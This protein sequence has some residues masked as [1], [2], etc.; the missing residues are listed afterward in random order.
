MRLL[1]YTLLVIV[2]GVSAQL[3]IAGQSPAVPPPQPVSVSLEPLIL[4]TYLVA[5]PGRVEPA[6]E[7]VAVGASV[8]GLVRAVAVKEGDRV[9]RGQIIAEIENDDYKAT[10]A[11]AEAALRLH[12]AELLRLNNGARPQERR[13][14][15]AAVQE[16]E[17]VVKNTAINF[18]RRRALAAQGYASQEVLDQAQRE[19]SVARQRLEMARQKFALIDD[20][21]R[22]ED[23]AIAQAQVDVARAARDEAQAQVD[24]TIVRS[25]ID[26]TVLK[27]TRHAGELVSTFIDLP[28]VTVGDVSKLLVRADVDEADIGRSS[29]A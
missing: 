17:A 20:R 21:A 15:Q 28:I 8:T 22:D 9:E 11:K 4:G 10:L 26:G 13:Q 5:A 27:V 25:P 6:S 23:I 3:I 7:E 16:A 2:T 19:N 24:K 18:E 29:S 14:A 12:E 1:L